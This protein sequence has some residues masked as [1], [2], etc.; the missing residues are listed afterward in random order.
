M[1]EQEENIS[2]DSKKAELT[3]SS[4]HYWQFCVNCGTRL[5]NRKCKLVCPKCGFFHSCSEP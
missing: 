3:D 1:E 4:D 2:K 5:E